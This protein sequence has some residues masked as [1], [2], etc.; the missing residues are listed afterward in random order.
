M[1]KLLIILL[2]SIN[3]IG[4]NKENIIPIQETETVTDI[5]GNIYH[6]IKIGTQIWMVENFK[7][8]HYNDGSSI[9]N[10]INN[11][12]WATLK[13]PAY[14]WYNNDIKNKEPYGALYN[15]FVIDTKKLCPKG[16]HIPN[17][18]INGNEADWQLLK[19]YLSDQAGSTAGGKL[20]EAG[21]K[22]WLSP[23]KDATNET[24]FTA[25]PAGCRN[26]NSYIDK[27]KNGAFDEL[28]I[29]CNFWSST[30]YKYYNIDDAITQFM[31]NTHGGFIGI[32]LDK[33]YGFSI[34]LIKD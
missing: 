21:E 28:G 31:T 24:G 12:E 33:Q 6:T 17:S 11:L 23:N 20:K 22:H 26:S 15:W 13:T 5:D 25:L 18:T 10:I 2:F 9:P 27:S 29:V 30:E 8:T 16:W 1:K 32:T 3:I 34:R 7:A 14:C 19:L 4:C